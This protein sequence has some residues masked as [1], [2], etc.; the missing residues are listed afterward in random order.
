[1][2]KEIHIK[3]NTPYHITSVVNNLLPLFSHP[4]VVRLIMDSWIYQR[5]HNG[6]KLYG[7]VIMEEHLHFMASAEQPDQC[8]SGFMEQTARQILNYLED[9]QLERFLMRL[10]CNEADM[11]RRFG[12][13]QKPPEIE[14]IVNVEMMRRTLDYIHIN[15]VKR[16]YVDR[17]EHWRYSSAKN[18]AG[19]VGLIEV[20]FF[21]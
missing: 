16:G 15:P 6:M 21:E 4:Q 17:A 2:E 8:L 19:E 11:Q 3:P 1:M 20:N 13:W 14:E 5:Q 10:A 9:Q 7:Y 12:F 18:Y